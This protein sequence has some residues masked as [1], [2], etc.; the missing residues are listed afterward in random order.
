MGYEDRGWTRFEQLSAG[1]VK[2][3]NMFLDLSKF[4]ED[5]CV[6]WVA[7][8]GI[9]RAARSPPKLPEEVEAQLPFK[10]VADKQDRLVLADMYKKTFEELMGSAEELDYSGLGWCDR[11]IES[12]A[13]VLPLCHNLERLVLANNEITDK[14]AELLAAAL[15]SC[16][17]LRVLQLDDNQIGDYGASKLRAA[18]PLCPTLKKLFLIRGNRIG[19]DPLKTETSAQKFVRDAKAS[20]DTKSSEG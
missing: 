11:D 14:G 17:R 5:F 16:K 3:R 8:E 4:D 15:P 7:T 12:L 19:I 20:E 13:D 10:Q 6:D 9:C 1:F 2:D 18:I